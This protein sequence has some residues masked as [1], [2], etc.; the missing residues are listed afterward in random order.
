LT[1][2]LEF[3]ARLEIRGAEAAALVAAGLRA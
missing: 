3:R 1:L 2:R